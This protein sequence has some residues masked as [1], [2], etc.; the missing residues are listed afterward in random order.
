VAQSTINQPGKS[1]SGT[2]YDNFNEKWLDPAKSL[3]TNPQCFGNVLECVREISNNK[4]RLVA[5]K[6]GTR[7]SDSGIH[8][9]ESEVYFVNPNV[10]N[11]ITAHVTASFSGTA[12]PTNNTDYTHTQVS[13]GGTFFN[14]GSG[15]PGDDIGVSLI[16]WIDSTKPS[17]QLISVYWGYL[18]SGI[19]TDTFLA[20]YPVGTE[21][22][23]SLKWDKAN[24]QF[25]AT[26][27]VKG[28]RRAAGDSIPASRHHPSRGPGQDPCGLT[29]HAELHQRADVWAGRSYFR[30]RYRQSVT[31][32]PF[33]ASTSRHP[34]AWS[35]PS[36]P[37]PS[38]FSIRSSFGLRII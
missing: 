30:Q 20:T 1:G 38:P 35:F 3:A 27:K 37:Q 29:A 32:Q 28:E 23:A 16:N 9:S 26:T 19:A 2:L 15:N 14:T 12:C 6:F 8:W 13:V 21:L 17:T 24:H 10:I 34:W 18:Y 11:S 7:D 25:I 33:W 36:G 31:R 4:L 5:R 22:T